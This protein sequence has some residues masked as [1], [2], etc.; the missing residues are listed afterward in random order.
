MRAANHAEKIAVN[1][2]VEIGIAIDGDQAA[3]HCAFSS[4]Q[5]NCRCM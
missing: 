5:E 1:V 4:N 2:A 3:P